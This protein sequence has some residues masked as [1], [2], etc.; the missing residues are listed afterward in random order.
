LQDS[1]SSLEAK[2]LAKLEELERLRSEERAL[3]AEVDASKWSEY[4]EA[5][6]R[7]IREVLQER[8]WR[9]Q[10]EIADALFAYRRVVVSSCFSSGKTF[11][12]GRLVAHWISTD[13]NAIAITTASVGRS[14]RK[15]LW[16]EIRQL[17]SRYALSG[18]LRGVDETGA[19]ESLPGQ[20]LPKA[21]EWNISPSNFALGFSTKDPN[22][23]S[24]WHGG[25][26]LLVLDEAEGIPEPLWDIMEGQLTSADVAVLAIGNPDPSGIGGGFERAAR[27][28]LWH[29]VTIS[30]FDT[31]NLVA[32]RDD[33]MPN[34]VT[35]RW[36]E[37]MRQTGGDWSDGDGDPAKAGPLWKTKVLGQFVE[38]SGAK[39]VV[40]LEWFERAER[41]SGLA[42]VNEQ[43]QAGLDI[44]RFGSDDSAIAIR[45]GPVVRHL[46]RIHGFDGVEVGSWAIERMRRYGCKR[47]NGDS[48]GL[49]GPV[50][51]F[52]RLTPGIHVNDVNAGE[53]ARDPEKFVRRRDELWWG[54][55]ERCE[56][57]RLNLSEL[58][59]PTRTRLRSQVCS[60]T[61]DYRLGG[62][63]EVESKESLKRR[64][65]PSPDDADALCLSLLGP[66]KGSTN[67]GTLLGG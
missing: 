6:G 16:G 62:R 55:R 48:T 20:L 35:N 5:P 51:D 57:N 4:R 37:E 27:S 29:H 3:L 21:A 40:L 41:A 24:G 22:M 8:L 14:I 53:R 9:V 15:Q 43:P 42:A 44:A 12:G 1:A 2:R 50:L 67:L 28:A 58:D 25:R 64:G 45:Q 65:L 11:L 13:P 39:H 23:F 36:V 63:I 56:Q 52:I 7:W 38:G 60:I 47:V 31:P 54:L 10:D 66:H 26:V 61:Y 59:A 18:R 49:G 19:L 46:E 34:L 33:V 32:G 17:H 30:A